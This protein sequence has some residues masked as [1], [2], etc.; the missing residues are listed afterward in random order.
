VEKAVTVPQIALAYIF[1][2]PL[3]CFAITGSLNPAH[4]KKNIEALEIGMTEREAAWLDL[5]SD[6]L[7]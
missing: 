3:N 2:Q 1:Q 6:S 5:R 7:A 4:F